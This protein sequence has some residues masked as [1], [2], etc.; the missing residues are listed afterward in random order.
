MKNLRFL[1]MLLEDNAEENRC[2][3]CENNCRNG[4]AN[5]PVV[6]VALIKFEGRQWEID[7]WD[8]SVSMIIS[9][10]GDPHSTAQPRNQCEEDIGSNWQTKDWMNLESCYRCIDI[11]NCQ[12]LDKRHSLS[13][14][15][16]FR[17]PS[18]YT[19]KFMNMRAVSMNHL[20]WFLA[21]KSSSAQL[22]II[23][24]SNTTAHKNIDGKGGR[25]LVLTH[26]IAHLMIRST[27]LSRS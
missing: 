5:P 11:L 15:T 21:C 20:Y 12:Q 27:A 18:A 6:A 26:S 17:G 10:Y 19:V 7:A 8:M 1:Y 3:A 4:E 24:K 23:N 9:W 13:R 2:S 16:T 22:A 14:L 25:F